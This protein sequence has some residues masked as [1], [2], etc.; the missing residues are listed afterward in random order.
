MVSHPLSVC[1]TVAALS[2]CA[3]KK[4]TDEVPDQEAVD[5]QPRTAELLSNGQLEERIDLN[6]DGKFE[7]TSL[8][9]P[10]NSTDADEEDG[11]S[12]AR[13]LTCRFE[14]IMVR[15]EIDLNWDGTPDRIR[16]YEDGELVSIVNDGD[17]DGHYEWT[18]YYQGGVLVLTEKDPD[19][20]GEIE[21]YKN[22]QAG[23]LTRIRRDTDG[24]NMI[25]LWEYFTPEG[26]IDK[27]GLDLDHDGIM[28][29]RR[30]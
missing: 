20:D 27:I 8:C 15:K 22:Y 2:A 4:G 16:H 13:S 24:D 19:G 25:D 5:I 18:D 11:E 21:I 12:S 6:G 23:R 30:E 3:A 14:A 17:F 1:V 10:T 26:E 7:V 9:Y 29:I 28:D